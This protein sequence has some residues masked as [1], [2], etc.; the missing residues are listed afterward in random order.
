MI[1]FKDY[2]LVCEAKETDRIGIQHLYSL[3][4]PEEYSMGLEV[5]E[6]L[7]GE[8]LKN[9]G[10]IS[11]DNSTASEKI[12]GMA[13]TIGKENGRFFM[14]SSFSG[15]VFEQS[16]FSEFIQKRR[17][18][19]KPEAAR[20]YEKFERGFPLLES[21][22]EARHGDAYFDEVSPPND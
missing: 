16:V 22:V 15:K 1:S 11:P 2:F 20:A 13:L 18:S 6:T 17:D 10:V 3:N 21:V 4:K 5:F 7:V 8:L 19:G 14:A 12:D 9:R